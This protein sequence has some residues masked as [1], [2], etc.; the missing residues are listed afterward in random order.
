MRQRIDQTLSEGQPEIVV[1]FG[2]ANDA[3]RHVDP[4]ETE[5]NVTLM[6][7]WLRERGVAGVVLI[8]P[9]L[10]NMERSP[11]WAPALE[12]V[13]SVLRGVAARTGAVFVDLAGFLRDRIE[14]GQDLDFTRLPY[15]Q[16]RSW[17]VRAGD[18][19]FNAYGQRLVAEAFLGATAG[20]RRAR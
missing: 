10:V 6:V 11:E 12:E 8:G 20:W 2:G 19:H 14:R 13:G 15:R 16:A 4:A 7:E 5:R 3:L 1:L 18:P 9:A 17:K